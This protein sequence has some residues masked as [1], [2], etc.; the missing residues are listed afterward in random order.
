MTKMIFKILFISF[1]TYA[2]TLAFLYFNQRNLL[3]FPDRTRPNPADH[4]AEGVQIIT[5]KTAD[6]LTLE[7]WYFPPRIGKKVI[8]HFHGNAS[9]A[10]ARMP[11]LR[12]FIESGYGVLLAEY[13]GYGGNSGAPTEAGLYEDAR[14]YLKFLLESK[15]LPKDRIVLYGESLGSGVATQ[16]ATEFPAA[17]LIL[18]APFT[19]VTEVAQKIYFYV[20]VARLLKDRFESI[21]KIASINMPLLIVHGDRDRTV[22]I[23]FGQKLFD[24]AREPK[25]F[26]LITGATHDDLYD[27]DAAARI[28]R[29]MDKLPARLD[30]PV[31][32]N[33]SLPN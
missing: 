29:F 27:H 16:M 2:I 5:V 15:K 10:A 14:A 13:R 20:T 8:V 30:S 9:T 6:G 31:E 11:R 25:Q 18:E 22:P 23:E 4:G 3:Y 33:Y 17:A 12:P 26:E 32:K 19:S 21:K 7:G 28:I 24:A 1:I